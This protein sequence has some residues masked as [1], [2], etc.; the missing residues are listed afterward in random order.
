M[1]QFANFI[2]KFNKLYRRPTNAIFYLVFFWQISFIGKFVQNH[3]SRQR[4][5]VLIFLS[6][7][8]PFYCLAGNILF[9]ISFFSRIVSCVF[10]ELGGKLAAAEAANIWSTQSQNSQYTL[11]NQKIHI[12]LPNQR[13]PT[14]FVYIKREFWNSARVPEIQRMS[15]IIIYMY[16]DVQGLCSMDSSTVVQA[17]F[18][19]LEPAPQALVTRHQQDPQVL[20][21]QQAPPASAHPVPP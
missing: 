6:I 9:K 5:Q 7:D 4:G 8:F 18:A 12:P 20:E 10:G 11:D 16:L 15:K 14:F 1:W 3:S 17:S 2:G 13:I 19:F 21:I